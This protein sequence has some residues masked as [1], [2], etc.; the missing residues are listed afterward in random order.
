MDRRLRNEKEKRMS[1]RLTARL[2][3][4][5]LDLVSYL[6]F[7]RL[8]KKELRSPKRERETKQE[9]RTICEEDRDTWR[10]VVGSHALTLICPPPYCSL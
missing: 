3:N 2:T 10:V 9:G 1:A 7:K 6:Y 5:T 8:E 4:F